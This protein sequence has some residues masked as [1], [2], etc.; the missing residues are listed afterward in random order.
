MEKTYGLTCD[1][2]GNT[3]NVSIARVRDDVKQWHH[4]CY[5]CFYAYQELERE[6]RRLKNLAELA[7]A[8]REHA[9][10]YAFHDGRLVADLRQAANYLEALTK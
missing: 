1:Q 6:H 4:M 10:T 2:C 7:E 3:P 5:D 8:L 9:Y